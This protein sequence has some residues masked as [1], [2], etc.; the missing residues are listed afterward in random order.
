MKSIPS[1]S[2]GKPVAVADAAAESNHHAQMRAGVVIAGFCTFL[3]VYATQPLLPQFQQLFSASVLGT[4]LTVSAVTLAVALAAPWVGLAADSVG[5]KRVIVSAIL[6]LSVPTCM[7]TTAT[8]L[9][10]LIGWRFAQG[11]F[12][13]GIIAV[14][15]AYIAEESRTGA[16]ASMTAAYVTGTVVGGMS[17]R[18]ITAAVTERFGWQNAFLVLALVTTAGGVL[19]WICLPRARRFVPQRNARESVRSMGGHFRNGRLLATYFVGFNSLFT[20]VGVFTCANFYLAGEPFR[21][22][23]VALGSVFFVYGLGVVVTPA[24]GP[25]IDR[26]GYRAAMVAAGLIVIAGAL[27][28]LVPITWVVIFGLA[29]LSSGI[30]VAQSAASSHIGA[31]ARTARSSAAGLYVFFYY[32]GGSAGATV[33]SLLWKWNGWTPCVVCVAAIQLLSAAVALRMF[34]SK[35]LAAGESGPVVSP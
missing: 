10:Q 4:S 26:F 35:P 7:A 20:M 34:A 14:T 11:L 24:A 21:L 15:L 18:F 2:A 31:V 13:P 33:L 25:L 1:M 17:G 23:L 6:G 9:A 28:T 27:L 19:A 16:A 29:I 5:R 32:L 30:F 12:V 22:G 3:P 8:T